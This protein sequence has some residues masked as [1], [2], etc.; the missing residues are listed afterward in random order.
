MLGCFCADKVHGRFLIDS[1]GL[2]PAGPRQGALPDDVG[3]RGQSALAASGVGAVRAP[4][5]GRAP[6]T[7]S[8]LRTPQILV[9][10]VLGALLPVLAESAT[11]TRLHNQSAAPQQWKQGSLEGLCPPGSHASEDSR[12]CKPCTSGVG[13]TNHSNVLPSCIS[14]TVCGQDEE[15]KGPCTTTRD[16]VCQCK[17]GTFRGKDSPE[18]CW[19][20]SA[21]CPNG[22]VEKSPC[23]PW[24]DLMCVPKESGRMATGEARTTGESVTTSPGTPASPCL[25]SGSEYLIMGIMIGTLIASFLLGLMAILLCRRYFYPGCYGCVSEWMNRVF[26][27]CSCLLRGSVL[28]DN[29]HKILSSTKSPSISVSEQEIEGQ[30]PA[31]L[32]DVTVVSPGEANHQLE[33]AE[34]EGSETSRRLLDPADGADSVESKRL[35]GGDAAGME[36][37]GSKAVLP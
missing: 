24:R 8:R 18:M 3:R 22:M 37:L 20:C 17:P 19:K 7:R 29:A 11:T 23:T 31:E 9:F 33:P 15:E 27:W 4:R 36:G 21:R 16:T 32:E 30:E 13:Y 6:G 26:S 1:G 5:P 34:A 35:V 28:W 14:C 25:Y 10:V 12:G 2:K